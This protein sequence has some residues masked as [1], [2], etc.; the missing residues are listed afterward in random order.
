MQVLDYHQS[1]GSQLERS[2]I[3]V[4]MLGWPDQAL[5]SFVEFPSRNSFLYL[6]DV[7]GSRFVP[8]E[9]L[10]AATWEGPLRA[11]IALGG[12]PSVRRR[13]RKRAGAPGH[14]RARRMRVS[15]S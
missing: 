13:N 2:N 11:F 14:V 6:T 15:P 4:D 7:L 3:R 5:A 1:I 9:C 10:E 8:T 12:A